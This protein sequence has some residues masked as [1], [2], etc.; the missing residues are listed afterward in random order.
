MTIRHVTVCALAAGLAGALA[1]P[2]CSSGDGASSGAGDP[3]GSGSGQGGAGPGSGGQGGSIFTGTGT[4]GAGQGGAGQGCT[5]PDMLLVLDRTMSMHKRPDGTIPPDTPAGH[6]ESKWYIAIQAV[7]QLTGS[8]DTTIRFGLE[9]FPR[10]PGMNQCITLSERIQG[11]TAT[12]PD[13]QQGE[14]VVQPDLE[15]SDEVAAVLDPE[16]T[17]LCTSTPIGAGLTTAR[18][19]LAAIVAPERPQFVVLIT[20][21]NETCNQNQPLNRTQQLAA[22]GVNTY[23][24]GFDASMDQVDGIDKVMLND[25]ACAGRT[26]PGFPANCIDDGNGN[27][28]WDAQS[29]TDVFLAAEDGAALTQVL[30]TLGGEVCCDCVPE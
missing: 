24:I 23:V 13:C 14:V 25:L 1:F 18:D 6:M 29:N 12:N 21:G 7:E 16:T 20:D 15:T 5:P 28:R 27:Y 8:L 17:E 3:T 22:A 19:A 9:L 4:G 10:N 30:E 26:S 11:I 2:S